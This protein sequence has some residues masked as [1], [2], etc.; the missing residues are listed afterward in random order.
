M[1]AKVTDS[2]KRKSPM[3]RQEVTRLRSSLLAIITAQATGCA[4]MAQTFKMHQRTMM[5]HLRFMQQVGLIHSRPSPGG[6]RTEYLWHLGEGPCA[7]RNYK[8][9]PYKEAV[10]KQ[11][12][13]KNWPPVTIPKQTIFS[14]LGL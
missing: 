8:V 6:G 14:S 5:N 4:K 10:V 13:V 3:S 2:P 12:R 1:T 11:L 7:T 9:K